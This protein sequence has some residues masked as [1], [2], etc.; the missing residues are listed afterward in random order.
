MEFPNARMTTVYRRMEHYYALAQWS[1][2]PVQRCR[3]EQLMMGEVRRFMDLSRKE[4]QVITQALQQ[5]RAF[6]GGLAP[7]KESL[8]T[9]ADLSQSMREQMAPISDQPLPP[10]T[11][12]L[13][14][15][16]QYDGAGGRPAYVAV[17]GIVY[18]V[19]RE[20]TWGGATHFGLYAGRDL[21]GPFSG[22]HGNVAILQALPKVGVLATGSEGS[23]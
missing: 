11:F 6:Q 20:A 22:C 16:A 17:N 2:C 13:A 5:R 9:E 14:D 8:S 21:T 4:Q 15:L 23:I 19:G 7:L 10:K 18:D 12:T 3:Y 1:A